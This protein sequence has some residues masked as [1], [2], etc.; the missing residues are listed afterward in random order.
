MVGRVRL[1]RQAQPIRPATVTD[2]APG[3]Q[4]PLS[5]TAKR[6]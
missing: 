1:V 6:I 3:D 4:A 2:H 5:D